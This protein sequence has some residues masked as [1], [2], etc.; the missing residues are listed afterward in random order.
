MPKRSSYKGATVV[1][2]ALIGTTIMGVAIGI[3]LGLGDSI[4]LALQGLRGDMNVNISAAEQAA[5][6]KAKFGDTNYQWWNN[7]DGTV[8][9]VVPP[10]GAGEKQ[11]CFDSGWCVNMPANSQA[12]SATTG[13]IGD[14]MISS[15]AAMIAQI[16]AQMEAMKEDLKDK[17]LITIIEK[18]SNFGSQLSGSQKNLAMNCPIGSNCVDP[19]GTLGLS[20]DTNLS[21]FMKYKAELVQYLE[22]NPGKVPDEIVYLLIGNSEEIV[23]ISDAYKATNIITIDDAEQTGV[24]ASNICKAGKGKSC[25]SSKSDLDNFIASLKDDDDDW[26]WGW[27]D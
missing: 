20:M 11:V 18:L 21:G 7:M 9:N 2:Y 15:H 19:T 5:A 10:P 25:D 8:G 1:E 23:E 16:K 24:H 17:Q 22:K 3:V 6:M 26:G 13:A 12:A 14:E 4:N 27:D